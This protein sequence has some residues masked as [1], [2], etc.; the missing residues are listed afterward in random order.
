MNKLKS[1][2]GDYNFT[3]PCV[4]TKF[5]NNMFQVEGKGKSEAAEARE[6]D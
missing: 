1:K 6:C 2:R 4:L 5:M 3:I